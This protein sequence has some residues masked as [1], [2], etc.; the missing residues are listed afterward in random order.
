MAVDAP[1]VQVERPRVQPE[2]RRLPRERFAPGS[3]DADRV[4]IEAV[5]DAEGAVREPI[6][7]G[8]RDGMRGLDLEALDAV[9][10][11]RF[12]PATIAGKPVDL[13]YVLSLNVGGG[14]KPAP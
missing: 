7:F 13:L 2:S 3:Y 12:R 4:F 10:G 11:W 6:L 8:R 9:C 1:D 14:A 5:V